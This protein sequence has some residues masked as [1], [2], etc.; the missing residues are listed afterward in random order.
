MSLSS[1]Y[2]LSDQY[3]IETGTMSAMFLYVLFIVGQLSTS[4]VHKM[5]KL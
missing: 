3:E 5:L 2:Y 4:I 1:I